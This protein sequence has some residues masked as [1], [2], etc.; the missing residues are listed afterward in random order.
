MGLLK[1]I[2]FIFL[3]FI[4]ILIAGFVYFYYFHTFYTFRICVKQ[5]F[6]DTFVSCLNKT[7]CWEKL[8]VEKRIKEI[9][10]PQLLEEKIREAIN[11]AIFC[12]ETCK[13]R[14]IYGDGITQHV[15]SCKVN[16]IEVKLEIKGKEGLKLLGFLKQ[17]LK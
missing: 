9:G 17:K 3:F 13:I 6:N 4:L 8:D 16:E 7:E 11:K 12:E 2:G 15:D 5:T 10:L 1:I 14:E